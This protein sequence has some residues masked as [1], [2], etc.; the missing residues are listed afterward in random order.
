MP[1]HNAVKTRVCAAGTE[2]AYYTIDPVGNLRP[3][4]HSPT[5]LGNVRQRNFWD[6][7]DSRTAREFAAARPQFC[8]G[9]RLEAACLGGCKAAAEAC[10]GDLHSMD[11]FLAAFA[12]QA[13][14]PA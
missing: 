1:S 6:L 4:N 5:I 3:C 14:K 7:V 2:R 13:V 10:C 12:G 8:S 11:P 9:C